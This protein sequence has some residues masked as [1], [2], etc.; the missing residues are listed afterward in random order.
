MPVLLC[1]GRDIPMPWHVY[2]PFPTDPHYSIGS[3]SHSQTWHVALRGI[4]TLFCCMAFSTIILVCCVPSPVL[5]MTTCRQK[6][7][8]QDGTGLTR[9]VCMGRF[10]GGTACA[11][12]VCHYPSRPLGITCRDGAA[13]FPVFSMAWRCSRR[14]PLVQYVRIIIMALISPF[15]QTTR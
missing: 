8:K 5:C 9:T 11:C 12:G 2:N 15:S 1:A 4:P 7:E 6:K 14:A 13:L 3:T 10:V